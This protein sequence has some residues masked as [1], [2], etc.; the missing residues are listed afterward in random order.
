MGVDDGQPS[1]GGISNVQT[2]AMIAPSVA[3]IATHSYL[4]VDNE[5]DVYEPRPTKKR[6]SASTSVPS[7]HVTKTT[8]NVGKVQQKQSKGKEV[9]EKRLRRY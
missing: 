8:A 1:S 9:E 3:G 2:K 5:D 6:K 7:K 4:V